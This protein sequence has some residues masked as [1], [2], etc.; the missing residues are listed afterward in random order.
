[1]GCTVGSTAGSRVK[2]AGAELPSSSSFNS[3]ALLMGWHCPH[4]ENKDD[5]S[6][7]NESNLGNS[8]IPYRHAQRFVSMVILNPVNLAIKIKH[9]NSSKRSVSS[10]IS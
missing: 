2:D 1:M 9:H 7:L 4:L 5:V 10:V 8:L 6:H 3:E